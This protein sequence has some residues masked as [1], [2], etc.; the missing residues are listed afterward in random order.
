MHPRPSLQYLSDFYNRLGGCSSGDNLSEIRTTEEAHWSEM[1]Y[2]NSTIDAK[3]IIGRLQ[4]LK[5]P[6]DSTLGQRR[7]LDVG[8]GFGFFSLEAIKNG[9]DVIAID[10]SAQER[11]ITKEIA[12]IDPI[13]SSFEDFQTEGKFDVILMSQVLEHAVDVNLYVKKSHEL[14][15]TGGILMAAVPNFGSLFRKLLGVR[16][17]YVTPPAHLNFFS[18]NNLRKLLVKNGFGILKTEQV[19]RI[20]Q[21][22]ILKRLPILSL[23]GTQMT[24]ALSRAFFLAMNSI[25]MGMFLNFYA[26]KRGE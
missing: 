14:L 8:S 24:N 22:V 7:F 25:K 5:P 26:I 21:R 11:M 9:Y 3:R 18:D 17:F 4:R 23:L 16:D 1:E 2:P 19:S 10:L 12:G 13:P 6:I 15:R 20:D